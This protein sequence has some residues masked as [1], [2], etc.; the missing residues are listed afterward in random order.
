M[1]T[2]TVTQQ[3]IQTATIY[4]RG[5]K[6]LPGDSGVVKLTQA[7]YDALAVKEESTLYVIITI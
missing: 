2:I 3:D 6:G 7:E 5:E 4:R 1:T